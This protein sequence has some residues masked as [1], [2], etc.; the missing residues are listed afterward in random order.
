[1][2]P[3]RIKSKDKDRGPEKKKPHHSYDPST[4]TVD[5]R[6]ANVMPGV[7]GTPCRMAAVSEVPGSGDTRFGGHHAELERRKWIWCPTN[8][9]A[10]R[11][12]TKNEG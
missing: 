2:L 3:L 7:P 1:M 11:R 5:L 6:L 4:N 10:A 8:R 12:K 9:K